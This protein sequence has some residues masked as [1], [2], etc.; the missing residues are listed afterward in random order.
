[1]TEKVTGIGGLFFRADSSKELAVWY[2]KHL[3]VSVVPSDY[4]QQPWMQESGPTVFAP[5]DKETDYFGN[6]KKVW[7]INF[8]VRDLDKMVAQLGDAGVEVKVDPQLYPNG[9]FARLY[10]P[11]GNPIELWEPQ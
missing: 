4:E 1:M 8:R 7:M 6:A 5:F 3:G 11:E 10:D 2:E 9:R